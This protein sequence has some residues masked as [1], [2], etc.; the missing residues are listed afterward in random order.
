MPLLTELGALRD[1]FC[2]KRVAPNGAHV[3]Q[4]SAFQQSQVASKAQ[5]SC[6]FARERGCRGIGDQSSVW[7]KQRR[8]ASFAGLAVSSKGTRRRASQ[9][10]SVTEVT[11]RS[12]RGFRQVL[13]EF[14]GQRQA[15]AF[16]NLKINR[17]IVRGCGRASTRT[18]CAFLPSERECLWF[19]HEP[20]DLGQRASGKIP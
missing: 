1:K 20:S 11:G 19:C 15:C 12:F 17:S 10:R 6:L 2:Y 3:L 7:T 8:S 14:G 4:H 13:V 16:E 9:G 18:S 5:R